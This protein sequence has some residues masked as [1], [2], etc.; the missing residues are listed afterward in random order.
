MFIK[1]Q[2]LRWAAH[3]MKME[4]TLNTD[5]HCMVYYMNL[6]SL[7]WISECSLS[8]RVRLHNSAEPPVLPESPLE[9]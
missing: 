9:V 7:P 5:L 4:N 3:A 2:R 6:M 1:S 8:L